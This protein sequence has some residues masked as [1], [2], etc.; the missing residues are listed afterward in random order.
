LALLVE[1][2]DLEADQLTQALTIR[3]QRARSP[4]TL[5]RAMRPPGLERE[6]GYPK[7]AA[8]ET[9]IP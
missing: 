9:L 4:V 6:T 1:E 8:A 7:F 2:L 5:P 3:A